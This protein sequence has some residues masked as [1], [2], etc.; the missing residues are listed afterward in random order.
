MVGCNGKA[1]GEEDGL[2]I[3]TDE[4]EADCAWESIGA[5]D[6]VIGGACWGFIGYA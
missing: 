1:G 3:A 6:E 2:A 5:G 4:E